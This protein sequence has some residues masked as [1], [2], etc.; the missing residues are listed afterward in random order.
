MTVSNGFKYTIGFDVDLKKE[1]HISLSTP[2][3]PANL[4][5]KMMFFSMDLIY[6]KRPNLLKCKVLEILAR[7]PYWAW[8]YEA[9][10]GITERYLDHAYDESRVNKT[11]THLH[12]IDM[13]REA[14]DNEQWHLMLIEDL[15]RQR[16]IKQGWV[17][18]ILIPRLMVMIYF[19]LCH[20]LS[21]F[22]P[23]YLLAMNAKFESHA[24]REYMTMVKNHPEWEEEKV[25]SVFF[26]Y[27]PRQKTMADLFRRI[28]LDERDHMNHS[29]EEYARMT[30]KSLI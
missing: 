7:Y 25:D 6:G 28:G 8:E 14:Q 9:Y 30:G 11:R 29:L 21:K 1:Q 12:H 24:E 16:G 18:A 23:H 20:A 26:Q 3:L 5:L 2:A 4:I 13:G 19:V 10:H 27:Y 17:R 15:M 22:F